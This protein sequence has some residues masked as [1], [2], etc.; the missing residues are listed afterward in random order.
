MY[1]SVALV[2]ATY[3]SKHPVI[4]LGVCETSCQEKKLLVKNLKSQLYG[5]FVLQIYLRKPS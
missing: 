1:I 5:R 3:P 4:T 2:R